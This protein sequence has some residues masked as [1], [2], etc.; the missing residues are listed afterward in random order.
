MFLY[1]GIFLVFAHHYILIS[2]YFSK[3]R[4]N[5]K[6]KPYILSVNS[7]IEC[8]IS[9]IHVLREIIVY[10]NAVNAWKHVCA[11]EKYAPVWTSVYSY[12]RSFSGCL[13]TL[14]TKTTLSRKPVVRTSP[15]STLLVEKIQIMQT[16]SCLFTMKLKWLWIVCKEVL[17]G[18]GSLLFHVVRKASLLVFGPS[19]VLKGTILNIE[20]EWT[21]KMKHA[22]TKNSA[23]TKQSVNCKFVD[24]MISV[25]W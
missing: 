19:S 16:T 21:L 11:L 5:K 1:F 4:R 7:C 2:K 18:S 22:S 24:K 14:E 13:K 17:P 3:V 8:D 20:F 10:V 23:C 9:D 12:Y 6:K 15:K 25:V